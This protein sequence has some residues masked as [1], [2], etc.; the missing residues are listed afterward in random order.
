MIS[1]RLYIAPKRQNRDTQRH[2]VPESSFLLR[3]R[4]SFGLQRKFGMY[5]MRLLSVH[6]DPTDRTIWRHNQEYPP[7]NLCSVTIHNNTI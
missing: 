1:T 2:E 5:I 7:A 3:S 6:Y 4:L